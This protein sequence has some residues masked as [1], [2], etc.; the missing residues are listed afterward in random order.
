MVKATVAATATV[1]IA[2]S[3]SRSSG[4]NGKD[5]MMVVDKVAVRPM[6]GSWDTDSLKCG[7]PSWRAKAT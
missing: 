6:T 2:L 3:G 1:M 5:G 4:K 7:K